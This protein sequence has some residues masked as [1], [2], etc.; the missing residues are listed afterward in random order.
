MAQTP[1]LLQWLSAFYQYLKSEKRYSPHTTSNYQRDLDRFSQ[2]CQQHNIENWRQVDSHLLRAY[3][4]ARHRNNISGRSLQ[5][6][7]SAIRSFFNFLCRE[8]EVKN[9][10]VIGVRAPK[11]A[12]KLP[13][14]LDADEMGQLLNVSKDTSLA[15]RDWAMMELMY[16][17]GL[18]LAE[19]ISLDVDSLDMADDSVPVTGKGA[20]TRIVP[21]GRFAK[22]SL[23]QWLA[24]RVKLAKMTE[25]A[26][27]V[28]RGGNRLSARSVQQR[29]K[30]WG[31]VQ[32]IDSPVH[33]HRL[34]HSF[35]SHL[36]ESSGDLRA[37]QELL[38]HA[39]ISTTQ[40]YTHIDFQHLAKVY[41]AAHPRARRTDKSKP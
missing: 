9:N 6:E 22:E 15:I 27:F 3:V 11:S 26:L 30:H 12:R 24:E 10:P 20:K 23:T 41:D 31:Q 7:L 35:A 29:M 5:R 25:S 8:Y 2:Y 17:G 40:I 39:D 16:S 1:R 14:P 32:G 38:G 19:L 34:R 21:I 18:R 4:A 33:P 28:S 37:V 13:T 36:L